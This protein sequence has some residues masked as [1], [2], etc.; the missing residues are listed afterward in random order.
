MFWG[1]RNP[2]WL[3]QILADNQIRF[4]SKMAVKMAAK[5]LKMVII[6]LIFTPEL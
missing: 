5:V 6:R 3:K 1:S 4:T 2:I